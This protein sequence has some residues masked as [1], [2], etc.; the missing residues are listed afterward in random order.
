M[1]SSQKHY[2][3]QN[4]RLQKSSTSLTAGASNTDCL[5]YVDAE[6]CIVA[7]EHVLTLLASQSLL[8]LNDVNLSH[9]DKQLIK[10]EL[11]TELSIF[12]D[13]MK[14]RTIRD[15]SRDEPLRRKKHG[16]QSYSNQTN[17]E[18]LRQ[19]LTTNRNNMKA[20]SSSDLLRVN[21]TRKLHLESQ[22]PPPISIKTP[23]NM[24]Q[25]CTPIIS[26]TN[27]VP[28]ER[29]DHITSSTPTRQAQIGP[30]S[31]TSE[32]IDEQDESNFCELSSIQL[33]DKDYLHFL[34]NLFSYICHTE[35]IT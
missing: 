24:S 14:K 4:E 25:Q 16:I 22:Q 21:L 28:K 30:V 32:S 12:H 27:T 29:N 8:A 2:G 13:L 3:D 19:K 15:A 9:R 31:Q 6:L 10:R 18:S 26:C 17:L 23:F 20:I 11:S 1:D 33:V 5:A 7:L 34:S 35:K